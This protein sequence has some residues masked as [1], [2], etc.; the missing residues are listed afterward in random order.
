MPHSNTNHSFACKGTRAEN[1]QIDPLRVATVLVLAQFALNNTYFNARNLLG[2]GELAASTWFS[3]KMC[4]IKIENGEKIIARRE[5]TTMQKKVRMLP[6]F[7]VAHTNSIHCYSVEQCRSNAIKFYFCCCQRRRLLVKMKQTNKCI[8]QNNGAVSN[9]KYAYEYVPDGGGRWWIEFRAIVLAPCLKGNLWRQH[10]HR[11][12][13]KVIARNGIARSD[14]AS[15][16][17]W[18]YISIAFGS[19]NELKSCNSRISFNF[20]VSFEKTSFERGWKKYFFFIFVWKLCQ[21]VLPFWSYFGWATCLS[22]FFFVRIHGILRSLGLWK[23]HFSLLVRARAWTV[24][25]CKTSVYGKSNDFDVKASN[26]L[27]RVMS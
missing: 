4:A 18:T 1:I 25:A 21:R 6:S 3:Q 20:T 11:L 12:D 16:M 15:R 8:S 19:K 17:K 9:S 24:F 22:S 7:M 26:I 5:N 23:F 14:N 10:A 13:F 27:C 2:P